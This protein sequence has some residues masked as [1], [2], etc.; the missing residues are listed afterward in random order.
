[1]S[2]EVNTREQ[3]QLT[4]V[5]LAEMLPED[6]EA[7]DV[8]KNPANGIVFIGLDGATQNH[9]CCSGRLE[10]LVQVCHDANSH[11]KRWQ[12]FHCRLFSTDSPTSRV[13]HR[14]VAIFWRVTDLLD[15]GFDM[16]DG[17]AIAWVR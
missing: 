12:V 9:F 10:T 6:V 14:S 7:F 3:D 17:R 8:L 2:G 1:M 15:A 4:G 16:L 13:S 5:D 11:V